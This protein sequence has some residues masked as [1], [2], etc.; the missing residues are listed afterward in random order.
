[1]NG[2]SA[3]APIVTGVAAILQAIRPT[4]TRLTPSQLRTIL[5][6]TATDISSTW[7]TAANLPQPMVRV[8]ALAAVESL[9]PFPRTTTVF[10]ADNEAPNGTALPGA[11]VALQIDPLTAK[12]SSGAGSAKTIGLTIVKGGQTLVAGLPRTMVMSPDGLRLYAFVSTVGTFGD[13]IAIIDTTTQ[14]AI[15]F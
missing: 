10:V 11:V 12:P 7:D 3:A 6:T 2:T 14:K 15:D 4:A 1:F 8:N 5:T 9:L 13:G